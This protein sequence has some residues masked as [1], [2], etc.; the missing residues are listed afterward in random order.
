MSGSNRPNSMTPRKSAPECTL[1]QQV[2]YLSCRT[3]SSTFWRRQRGQFSTCYALCSASPPSCRI[4][5]CTL[6]NAG[7]R[8]AYCLS[9]S[10]SHL[11]QISFYFTVWLACAATANGHPHHSLPVLPPTWSSRSPLSSQ[12]QIRHLLGWIEREMLTIVLVQKV[13]RKLLASKG[14]GQS[15][16]GQVRQAVPLATR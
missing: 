9:L 2:F 1:H 8:F 10:P 13:T 3:R 4:S 16:M 11:T 15:E 6:L 14:W 5:R 7:L 12:C